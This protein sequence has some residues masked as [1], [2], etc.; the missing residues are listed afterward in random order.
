MKLIQVVLPREFCKAWFGQEPESMQYPFNLGSY[1]IKE[2]RTDGDIV[3]IV[4]YFEIARVY[5]EN[6]VGCKNYYEIDE[7]IPENNPKK[8]GDLGE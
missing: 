1:H 6:I 2:Q 8:I 7:I 5:T 4:E 3:A